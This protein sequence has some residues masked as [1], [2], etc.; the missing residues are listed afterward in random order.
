MACIPKYHSDGRREPAKNSNDVNPAFSAVRSPKRGF[1]PLLNMTES[2]LQRR[3]ARQPKVVYQQI[4]IHPS[5]PPNPACSLRSLSVCVSS[6]DFFSVVGKSLRIGGKFFP[7]SASSP[8]SERAGSACQYDLHR[9]IAC[10]IVDRQPNRG[11]KRA[12]NAPL[13]SRNV[14]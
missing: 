14:R 12:A 13:P 2:N 6:F 10:S 4:C 8:R 9:A 1:T 3:T 7:P 5:I 11:C